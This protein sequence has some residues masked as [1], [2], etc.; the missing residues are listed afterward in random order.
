M[1]TNRQQIALLLSL[2]FVFFQCKEE[3]T[4]NDD[5]APSLPPTSSFIMDFDQ[6]PEEENNNG[7]IHAGNYAHF[8]Y[9]SGNVVVW[10]T[11]LTLNL[12]L[13]VIAFNES[14]NHEAVYVS[15]KKKWLWQYEVENE[16]HTHEISLYAKLSEDQVKWE[17]FVTKEGEYEDFLWFEGTS[18]FDKTEGTWTVYAEPNGDRRAYLKIDWSR[19]D[20]G[21]KEIKYI[22]INETSDQM[23]SYIHYAINE[24]NDFESFYSIYLKKEDN[25]VEIHYDVET[26]TGRVKSEKNFGTDAWYCWDENLL[27]RDC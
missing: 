14:F 11:V 12:A 15:D 1:K 17:M 13:P 21:H 6:F 7:R 26:K 4:V 18:H 22:N 10:Q 2:C 9:A 24:S 20:E 27:N 5:A 3:E 19:Q 16:R 8:R 23:G 25:L